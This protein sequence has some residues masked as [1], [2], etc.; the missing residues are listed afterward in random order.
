MSPLAYA[1]AVE[2]GLNGLLLEGERATEA[3]GGEAVLVDLRI[4]PSPR[5][6]KPLSELSGGQQGSGQ[7]PAGSQ[8][9]SLTMITSKP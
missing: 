6:A 2:P 1:L 8:D 5:R 9:G 3:I 4:N 7:A